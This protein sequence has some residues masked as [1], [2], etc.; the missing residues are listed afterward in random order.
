MSHTDHQLTVIDDV[1]SDIQKFPLQTLN[2]KVIEISLAPTPPFFSCYTVSAVPLKLNFELEGS[3]S[4]PL[5]R[6]PQMLAEHCC[7]LIL[8]H[9]VIKESALF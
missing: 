3:G 2:C 6:G 4:Q 7:E 9:D 8:T 1:I 5:L